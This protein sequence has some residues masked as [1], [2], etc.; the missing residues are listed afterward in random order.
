MRQLKGQ[1]GRQS[2]IDNGKK[3]KNLL[4]KKDFQCLLKNR[5]QDL[6]ARLRLEAFLI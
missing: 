4:D 2:T 5:K 3:R 6:N 1:R